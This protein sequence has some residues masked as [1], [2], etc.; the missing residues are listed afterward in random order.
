MLKS[1]YIK[2]YAIIDELNIDFNSGFNVF[3]GETGAGKS[4]I[5]GALTY[6]IKGKADPSVIKTN[7]DKAII[8]GIFT[9]DDYMKFK[10][11]DAEIEYDDEIIV[12]RTISKDGHN[13]IKINQVSV[14]LSFLIDLLSEHID[15]HSQK[16]SQYLLNKKNHL[17]LLDK[18]CLDE[19]L[20]NDYKKIYDQYLIA[21]KEYNE[22][23]NNTYN[24]SEL[25]Y[26]KYD[27]DE[28]LKANIDVDEEIVLKD[29]EKRY[30]SQEKYINVLNNALSL[31]DSD[32]G[33]KERL[34]LLTKELNIDD[35]DISE[36][37]DN[38]NNL[39]YSLDDEISK[40]R[41][42]LSSFADDDMDI[43]TIEER[44]YLYS[45]LQRKHNCDV[46]GL[47]HK[48]DYLKDKIAFF[49]NKDNVLNNKKMIVDDLCDQCYLKAKQIHD[50]RINKAADLENKIVLETESLMLNNVTFKVNIEECD[51]NAMA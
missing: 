3:T 38:I 41:N 13:S 27:L 4:I 6:L 28:L 32:S 45:K 44:L 7:C 21:L 15:I 39:Y 48:I 1:L 49:E 16:D 25:E 50:I 24:E 36:A 31:Y 35:N 19:S 47:L 51:I 30:K 43:N 22:L 37:K 17:T 23:L 10:L 33:I 12:R 34:K 26:Y 42:I 8:E 18:Y 14:T 29:K 11:E 40:L 20:V 5:V 2:N 46:N 9:V